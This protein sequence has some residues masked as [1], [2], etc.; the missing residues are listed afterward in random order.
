MDLK[1]A[2]ETI[3]RER[4]LGKLYLYGIRGM[5][6]KWFRS[7]LENRIQQSDSIIKLLSKY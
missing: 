2:F 6:L 4:L 1:R 3:D 5:V 7:Y